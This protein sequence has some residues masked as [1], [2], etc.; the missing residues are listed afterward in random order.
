ML[1][2]CL[3]LFDLFTVF[4]GIFLNYYAETDSTNALNLARIQVGLEPTCQDSK[5]A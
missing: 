4:S 5:P 1:F 2:H 3:S